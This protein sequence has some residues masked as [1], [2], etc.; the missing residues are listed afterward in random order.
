MAKFTKLNI[1]DAVA[2][3]GGRVWKKLSAESAE[4]QDELAGT[5]VF[6]EVPVGTSSGSY[7]VKEI[8]MNFS[9]NGNTFDSFQFYQTTNS[10]VSWVHYFSGDVRT[11]AYEKNS[12]WYSS[13]RTI[14]ITSKLSEVNNGSTWLDWLQANATKQ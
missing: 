11:T 3:S 7:V 4:V 8:E 5:W 2:S 6:N 10:T 12:G 13:Y 9:S 14:Y 1:G